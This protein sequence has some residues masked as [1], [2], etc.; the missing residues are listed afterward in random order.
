MSSSTQ[1]AATLDD[2]Y[3]VEGKAELIDEEGSLRL[4]A[5]GRRPNQIASRI[6][7]SL[8]RP[9]AELP[10]EKRAYTDNIGFAATSARLGPR[11]ILAGC[12]VLPRPV[13]R[14]RNA[15]PRRTS[16]LSQVEVR[17][18]NDYGDAADRAR[19]EEGGLLRGG[20]PRLCGTSTPSPIV[21]SKYRCDALQISRRS[22]FEAKSP[23]LRPRG[24]PKLDD[25]G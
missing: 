19:R 22:S 14:E 16:G 17:G 5:T 23:T 15:V 2:L 12:V 21:S 24:L 13:P 8:R 25:R 7:R 20:N 1:T 10:A 6:F 4:M 3:R 11:V 18:E 9:H